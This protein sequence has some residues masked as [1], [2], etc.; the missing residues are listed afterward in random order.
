[1]FN[2]QSLTTSKIIAVDTFFSFMG[3]SRVMSNVKFLGVKQA[4]RFLP[5]SYRG[6]LVIKYSL[7]E[8]IFPFSLYSIAGIGCDKMNLAKA[9]SDGFCNSSETNRSFFS[10]RYL[11]LN[12]NSNITTLS[13]TSIRLL[14]LKEIP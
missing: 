8:G 5:E 10:L 9:I 14:S 11:Y 12:F 7:A 13:P 2:I 6:L 1:M 3:I 4:R